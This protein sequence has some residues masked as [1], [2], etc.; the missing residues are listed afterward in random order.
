MFTSRPR[1]FLASMVAMA[2]GLAAVAS[3]VVH[4]VVDV[5][6][7]VAM[8][9]VDV[10]AAPS[11]MDRTGLA[12]PQRLLMSAQAFYLRLVKR[13]RPVVEGNFRMCPST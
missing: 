5:F 13:E 9:M 10:L 8:H 11:K 3:A 2:A 7:V 4:R 1:Y 6:A 12:V